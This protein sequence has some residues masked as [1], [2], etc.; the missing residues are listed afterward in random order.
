[1]DRISSTLYA[2]WEN[3][4][5]PRQITAIIEVSARVS[6][7]QVFR[8]ELNDRSTIIAKVSSYGS[9]YLFREDHDRLHLLDTLLAETR[10]ANLLADALLKD[11]KIYTYYHDRVWA[12]FYQDVPTRHYLP[13]ILSPGQID[14]L[15]RRLA[16][17]HKQ[18]DAIADQIPLTSKSIKSDVIHLLELVRLKQSGKIFR[19]K[20]RA[21][22]T[23][24]AHCEAFLANLDRIRYG[25]W[26]K[27]PVLIDWNLG[28]FSVEYTANKDGDQAP[29]DQHSDD[30]QLYSRWDYDWFR[31]EP[32]VLDFY[33]CARVAS[34]IGDRT[35]FSYL[36]NPLLEDRFGIFLRAY[37]AER[38]L[39]EAD[40]LFLKEGYRFFILNYVILEGDHFFRRSY[41]E[42]LRNEAI[43]EYLP[44]LER[45]DFSVLAH[46]LE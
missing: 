22:Q 27:I 44:A 12:I 26:R 11:G 8:L 23:L 7:N 38:P 13:R 10:Y 2:A 19:L 4:G 30:F 3:Y 28:N 9:Y 18:C 37:H 41:A 25:Y 6:T 14:C 46:V 15:G 31:I 32:S 34:K 35:D 5:D 39:S 16:Q 45:L 42:R 40:L 33:F 24:E 36:A 43:E 20:R 1:M 17:F 29:V 21:L